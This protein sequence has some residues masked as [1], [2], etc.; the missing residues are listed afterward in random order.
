METEMHARFLEV[1]NMK[2]TLDTSPGRNKTQCNFCELFRL[3]S[4]EII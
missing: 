4:V 1:N 2:F 3:T